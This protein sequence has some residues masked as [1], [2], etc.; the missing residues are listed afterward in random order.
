MSF[1]VASRKPVGETD[2]SAIGT[3]YR[4]SYSGKLF[5][6]AGDSGRR[7]GKSSPRRLTIGRLFIQL[8]FLSEA[9]FHEAL[10]LLS[11]K[12]T[13]L[14]ISRVRDCG[15]LHYRPNAASGRRQT[16]QT[17]DEM[18]ITLLSLPFFSSIY[19]RHTEKKIT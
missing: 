16:I 5:N 14:Y 7:I 4:F 19:L 9:I 1:V 3:L 8:I 10:D 6:G 15:R 11:K 13:K 12:L 17:N 18:G 2:A